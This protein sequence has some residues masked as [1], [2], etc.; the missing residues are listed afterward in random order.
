MPASHGDGVDTETVL[1]IE[2]FGGGV[3]VNH[4]NFMQCLTFFKLQSKENILK[5]VYN[6]FKMD[7]R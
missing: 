3:Y 1:C 4:L 6:K 5:L 7:S 2:L